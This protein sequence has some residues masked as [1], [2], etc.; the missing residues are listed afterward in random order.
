LRVRRV[1]VRGWLLP[2]RALQDAG[3]RVV[4]YRWRRLRDL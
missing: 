4:R 3:G 1:H 2:G